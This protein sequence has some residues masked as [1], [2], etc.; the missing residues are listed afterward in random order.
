[1]Q[2][3]QDGLS[4]TPKSSSSSNPSGTQALRITIEPERVE[5]AATDEQASTAPAD[6][7]SAAEVDLAPLA[8]DEHALVAVAAELGEPVVDVAPMGAVDEPVAEVVFAAPSVEPEMDAAAAAPVTAFVPAPSVDDEQPAAVIADEQSAA[9]AAQ[10]DADS[11]TADMSEPAALEPVV[12]TT[13]DE[14]FPAD[15][16][17][18]PIVDAPAPALDEPGAA[19]AVEA[20]AEISAAPHAEALVEAAPPEASADAVAAYQLK[21]DELRQAVR[22]T[23]ADT[24]A[25]RERT[26]AAVEDMSHALSTMMDDARHDAALIGRKLMEFVQANFENNI[27]MARNYAGAR[28][29]PEIVNVHTAYVRRQIDL[30]SRQAEEFRALTSDIAAKRV[31][32]IQSRIKA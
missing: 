14:P 20:V 4:R 32:K 23:L 8:I 1:M 26:E 13:S 11:A 21:T 3:D 25:Q 12:A 6:A 29:M 7:G 5:P 28:S 2:Q 30:L 27:E 18:K 16:A 15:A 17:P 19:P 10:M 24:A 9:P 31:G 22:E